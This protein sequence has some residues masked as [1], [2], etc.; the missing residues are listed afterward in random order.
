ML[1]LDRL[2]SQLNPQQVL[3]AV[4][5][6]KPKC[7]R[8]AVNAALEVESY[9]IAWYE[10]DREKQHNE[11]LRED[12][13]P[14]T[15]ASH[16]HLQQLEKIVE[17]IQLRLVNCEVTQTQCNRVNPGIHHIAPLFAENVSR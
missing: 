15:T 1:A 16:T 14:T 11:A 4:K 7:V 17:T 2:L 6:R 13:I 3:L 9:L 8:E 5:Q 10:Y 12:R